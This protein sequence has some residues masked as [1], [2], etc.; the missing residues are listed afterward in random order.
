MHLLFSELKIRD[1]HDFD[2]KVFRLL[3]IC[4]DQTAGTG[5]QCLLP[6]PSFIFLQ[7]FS[8]GSDFNIKDLFK[9]TIDFHKKNLILLI[10]GTRL[11]TV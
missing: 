7:R 8:K 10:F 9:S 11:L 4:C 1:I 2:Q 5:N 6:F 3:Q